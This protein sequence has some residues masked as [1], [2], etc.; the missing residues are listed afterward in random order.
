MTWQAI[1]AWPN[2]KDCSCRMFFGM[3]P[4]PENVDP[5]MRTPCLSHCGEITGATGGAAGGEGSEEEEEEPAV[6]GGMPDP[7]MRPRRPWGGY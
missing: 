3:E 2:L 1:S 7:S 4:L 6:C 5:A